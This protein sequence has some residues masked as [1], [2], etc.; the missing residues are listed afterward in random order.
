MLMKWLILRKFEVFNWRRELNP[1]HGVKGVTTIIHKAVSVVKKA[2]NKT[3]NKPAARPAKIV[4]MTGADCFRNSTYAKDKTKD[5]QRN[6]DKKYPA[7]SPIRTL[8]PVLCALKKWG[9]CYLEKVA[10]L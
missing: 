2:C 7:P 6:V 10:A 9:A 1:P 5:G 3:A 8:T 4:L